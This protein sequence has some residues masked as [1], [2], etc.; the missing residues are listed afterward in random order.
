[1]VT[2]K[3]GRTGGRQPEE[4]V[5]GE[6]AGEKKQPARTKMMKMKTKLLGDAGGQTRGSPLRNVMVV[7]MMRVRMKLPRQ[8]EEEQPIRG[9]EPK[10]RTVMMRTATQGK[11]RM[12]RREE[13]RREGGGKR[14]LR[15]RRVMPKER[16]RGKTRMMTRTRRKRRRR[17]IGRPGE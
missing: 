12:E 16:T 13:E 17:M 5:Q 14:T 6:E 9:K 15:V 7:M 2:P 1:M 8:N 4:E 3:E 11:E 10:P